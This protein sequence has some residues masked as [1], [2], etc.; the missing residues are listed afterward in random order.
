MAVAS[1]ARPDRSAARQLYRTAGWQADFRL[2]RGVGHA[3]T[4]AMSAGVEA[5]FL[6]ALRAR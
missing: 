4:S 3:M 5:L 2:Y 6:A 1:L